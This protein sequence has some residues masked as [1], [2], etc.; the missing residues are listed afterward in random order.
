M[1]MKSKKIIFILLLL[2]VLPALQ[3]AK[4]HCRSGVITNAELTRAEIKITNLSQHG[5]PVFP[6]KRIYAVLTIV[7]APLR[8]IS[9]FDHSLNLFGVDYPCV[10]IFR[11]G[12]F[13]YFTGEV[14]ST[15]PQQLIFILDGSNVS[16]NDAV[17]NIILKSNLGDAASFHDTPVPFNFINRNQPVVPGK[18]PANGLL[19]IEWK[20]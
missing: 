8:T 17:V 1:E 18:I 12:K 11:N 14:K 13:E 2:A 9:I 15:S 5:F 7:P 10:G 20:R 19:K 6:A 3:A 16:D 4:L